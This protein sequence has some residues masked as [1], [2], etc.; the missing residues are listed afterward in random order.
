[1]DI[2]NCIIDFLEIILTSN[3]WTGLSA[4]FTGIAA[5]VIIMA[6][7]QLNFEAWLKAQDLFTDK[8]FVDA[9]T[10][11]YQLKSNEYDK[12]FDEEKD[13]DKVYLV[14]RKMDEL[15]R[16]VPF[17]GEEKVLETWD[18]PFARLWNKLEKFI[19]FERSPAKANWPEKWL[20]FEDIGKKAKDRI[21]IGRASCRERV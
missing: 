8:E 18:N 20:P 4:I 2:L 15:A 7:K 14:C 10:F 1:M 19:E 9:R 6:R 12:W 13:K 21:E 5:Y 16:L 17:L 11:V 3:I